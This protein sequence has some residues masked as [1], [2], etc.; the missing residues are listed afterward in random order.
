MKSFSRAP[1]SFA[2]LVRH[3]PILCR[4]AAI[5]CL[6]VA[7]ARPQSVG[8]QVHVAGRGVSIVVALDHSGSMLAK[9]FPEGDSKIARLDAAKQTLAQFIAGRPDDLIGLI[10]FAN[11]PKRLSA[12]TLDHHHLVEVARAIRSASPGEDGTNIGHAVVRALGELQGLPTQR[13]VLVLLTDGE[14][15]PAVPKPIDPRR[16]AEL[17][18]EL[19]V[20]LHTIA[21]GKAGGQVRQRD[22]ETGLDLVGEVGGPNL[23]LLDDMARIGGGR[24]FSATD[25]AGLDEVFRVINGLEKSPVRGAVWTRYR[26]EYAPWVG[27]A[28]VLL[29]IDRFL[30]S[31]RLRRVP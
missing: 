12:P 3:V 15:R 26:E 8:G 25:A 7:M 1:R 29:A 2:G 11:Y 10:A 5:G 21:L 23:A 6:A 19:G 24:S 9:D 4:T 13:K 17:A 18:R 30:V 22:Q 31:G 20:T 28:V 27:A 14:D 16:A